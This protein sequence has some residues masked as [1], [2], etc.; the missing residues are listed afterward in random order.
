MD[1]IETDR[2]ILR[3]WKQEDVPLFAEMNKDE[4]VM[5]YFPST[6]TDDQIVS[7]YHRIQSEFERNG[8]GL[9]AVEL[10][11]NGM[12]IGYVG[13]HEIGFDADF[14]PGIEIGWRLAAEYHNRGFATEAATEV[15]KQAKN[16]GLAELYSFTAKLNLSSEKV[17]QKIGMT[18]V[19]EFEHPN[20][21][22]DSP[23]R[24]HVL[25]HIDLQ[26]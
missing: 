13:L 21:S 12:F 4:R 22:V 3:L 19:G 2:L 23:L 5:R 9:Y 8:W 20:L 15:L 6:L 1:I 11:S 7:F 10:K 18:K 17:M 16:K 25:Y 14:T 24:T 26:K